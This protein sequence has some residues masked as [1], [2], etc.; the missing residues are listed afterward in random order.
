MQADLQDYHPSLRAALMEDDEYLATQDIRVVEFYQK[1]GVEA[2]Y[3]EPRKAVLPR[4]LCHI[5]D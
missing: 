3:I 1:H 2:K 4:G 5:D